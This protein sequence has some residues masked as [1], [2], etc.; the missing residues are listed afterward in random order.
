MMATTGTILDMAS[1]LV[2]LVDG[3]ALVAVEVDLELHL[4]LDLDLD[5]DVELV[6][7][8]DA[9]RLLDSEIRAVV[10]KLRVLLPY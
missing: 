2:G 5:L 6:L 4:D 1:C 10:V 3:A 9:R 7:V 8:V